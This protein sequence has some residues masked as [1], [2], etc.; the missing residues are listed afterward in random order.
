MRPHAGLRAPGHAGQPLGRA[1]AG[2]PVL[3]R[4]HGRR[5]RARR[6]VR[7]D[8]S[9]PQ[10][11]GDSSMETRRGLGSYVARPLRQEEA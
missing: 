11:V 8:V 3:A 4:G 1:G 2:D 5:C 10:L 7:Q 9:R 6:Q